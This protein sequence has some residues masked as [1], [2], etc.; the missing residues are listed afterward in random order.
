MRTVEARCYSLEEKRPIIVL[1]VAM[2][3]SW[4]VSIS[5]CEHRK[6]YCTMGYYTG[7]TRFV[8][9]RVAQD[10]L[11]FHKKRRAE[12]TTCDDFL[13][14]FSALCPHPVCH[15]G[16]FTVSSGNADGEGKNGAV[17]EGNRRNKIGGHGG[18]GQS[19]AELERKGRAKAGLTDR[20]GPFCQ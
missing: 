1:A 19:K 16:K 9:I 15:E 10:G 8:R 18:Q 6:A 2:Y 20:S 7:V 12:T 14:T 17:Q 4:R 5:L 11:D 13:R 3:F